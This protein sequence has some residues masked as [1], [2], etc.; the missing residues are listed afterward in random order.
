MPSE[1]RQKKIVEKLN[2]AQKCSILRPQ[3]LGSGGGP[4]PPGPPPWIRTCFHPTHQSTSSLLWFLHEILASTQQN[5]VFKHTT[6]TIWKPRRSI[7]QFLPRR[8]LQVTCKALCSNT[9][10]NAHK[11][12]HLVFPIEFFFEIHKVGKYW[13]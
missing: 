10:V 12:L 11:V 8:K 3:N 9:I 1:A 6:K 2:R 5:S 7:A 13:Y 4:G